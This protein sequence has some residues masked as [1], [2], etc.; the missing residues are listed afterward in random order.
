MKKLITIVLFIVP[1]FCFCQSVSK[2]KSAQTVFNNL[3]QAY[4]NAKSAPEFKIIP[5]KAG[6]SVI[7]RYIIEDGNHLIEI[8]EKL[9]NICFAMGNDSLNSLAIILS[10]ELAHYYNDHEWC[11]DYAY[12]LSTSNLK[13]ANKINSSSKAA[14]TEK[15][16]IADNNGLFY[17]SVA[18]YKV[19]ECYN[20]L[21]DQVYSSYSLP[22]NQPGY[23]SLLDRKKIAK[24]GS[25]KSNELYGYFKSGIKAI[26]DSK[27]D[28]AILFF[29]KAN[30]YIPYRENYNNLGVAKT[31]KAL[32]IKPKSYEE[33]H[34]PDRFLY[35]LEV[36]NKSRL[37]QDDSRGLDEENAEKF[38]TLLKEAQKD[39][40]EAIRI[41]PSFT[42]SY[43][44]LA[45]V[46]DLMDNWE[47]AIGKI[48][49]LSIEQQNTIDAKRIL[50]IAYYHNGQ[51]DKAEKIWNTFNK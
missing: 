19:F 32:I 7:A 3:V 10:H 12:A 47:G 20:K 38:N 28:E 2:K 34:F 9:I 17:A 16:T 30:A 4:A 18:G 50:A 22:H 6:K 37:S 13:L 43:I 5:L 1:V 23:P 35:P 26:N 14:K 40:Q 41:D 24:D 39:F 48:K 49:E 36:E 51:E 11:S 31:R 8:D 21:L 29:K 45:C 46:Y 33:V 27:Y 42:K 15:E 44:N 25:T